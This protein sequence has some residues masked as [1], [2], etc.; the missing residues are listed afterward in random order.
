MMKRLSL[1]LAFAVVASLLL[2]TGCA[3]SKQARSVEHEGYLVDHSILVKGEKGEAL[4]RYPNPDRD[5]ESYNKIMLDPILFSQPDNASP[6]QLAD[7]QKLA[8]N[9][10]TYLYQELEKDYTMVRAAEPGAMRIQIA[11]LNAQ[12]SNVVTNTVSSVSPIGMGV[13]VTKDFVTGKS[14]GVG[15]ITAEL[16]ATDAVTGELL[17]AAV[18]RRVG[19]KNPN[20]IIDTWADANAAMEYWA[21]RL[22][23]TLCFERGDTE[24][25]M[26]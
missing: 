1:G 15:E 3:S 8:N 23:H 21:K 7:L 16:K 6:A 5:L 25:V 20:S 17:G 9:F 10:Y 11:I 4:L 14:V 26:P 24:C 2:I 12:K 22:S 18:D 13:S 19:G